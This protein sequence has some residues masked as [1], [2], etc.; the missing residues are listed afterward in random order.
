MVFSFANLF[1]YPQHHSYQSLNHF[2]CQ[3]LWSPLSLS[4]YLFGFTMQKSIWFHV[5]PSG[6]SQVQCLGFWNSVFAKISLCSSANQLSD[7]LFHFSYLFQNVPMLWQSSFVSVSIVV[8]KSSLLILY[9]ESL[10]AIALSISS[11]NCHI[12]HPL[13]YM[14]V[15]KHS[16]LNLNLFLVNLLSFKLLFLNMS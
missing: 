12:F 14:L 2:L 15:H 4:L 6:D 10:S 1:V 3:P 11:K 7:P 13:R 8:L 9:F 16:S 5:S